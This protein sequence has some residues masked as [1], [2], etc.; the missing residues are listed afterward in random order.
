MGCFFAM[1]SLVYAKAGASFTWR[2]RSFIF[3]YIFNLHFSHFHS[4]CKMFVDPKH[5]CCTRLPF[6]LSD[7]HHGK[8]GKWFFFAW[9]LLEKKFQTN[10]KWVFIHMSC[11]TISFIVR[12]LMDIF[13]VISYH[14]ILNAKS[15]RAAK[16]TSNAFFLLSHST[17]LADT[18]YSTNFM[19]R[20]NSLSAKI[21]DYCETKSDKK[22]L[23]CVLWFE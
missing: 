13:S 19:E 2:Q 10:D 23:S 21:T 14:V 16:K 8:W 4:T 3:S 18:P 11:L 17:L 9:K 12:L 22:S 1:D 7:Q 15:Q 5:V 20:K 6:S